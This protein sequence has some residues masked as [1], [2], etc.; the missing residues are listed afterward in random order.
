LQ[1][2]RRGLAAIVLSGIATGF[3]VES[4]ARDACELGCQQVFAGDA[5]TGIHAESH[6]NAVER[7]FPRVGRV[8]GTEEIVA[9]THWRFG[10]QSNLPDRIGS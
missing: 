1:L 3:G 2:R 7:I 8:R 4:A 6:A 9:A 5:M 10:V